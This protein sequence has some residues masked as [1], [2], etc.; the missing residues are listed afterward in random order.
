MDQ[1]NP[2]GRLDQFRDRQQACRVDPQSPLE[3]VPK[4]HRGGGMDDDIDR[5]G[6]TQEFG[7]LQAKQRGSHL[8]GDALNPVAAKGP[9]PGGI[10][11]PQPIECTRG[12]HLSIEPLAGSRKPLRPADQEHHPRYLRH[13]AD[14]LF[15]KD[16]AEE[17]RCPGDQNAFAGQLPAHG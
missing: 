12:N 14:D 2:P 16:L 7:R 8:P 11:A 3:I 17:P 10:L 1:G 13:V 15:Q 9:K 4:F 5:R 6:Q